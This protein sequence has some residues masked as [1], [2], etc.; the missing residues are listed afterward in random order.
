MKR[1]LLCAAVL[2]MPAFAGLARADETTMMFWDPGSPTASSSKGE[3]VVRGT[4]RLAKGW[5]VAGPVKLEAWQNGRVVTAEIISFDPASRSWGG[6]I[7]GLE[8]GRP[9]NV[10]V[11]V[12]VSDGTMEPDTYA[13]LGEC[14][15]R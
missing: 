13:L 7:Q 9:Y 1:L 10:L 2:G 12:P 3:V 6:S 5:V 4:I 15:V 8:S 11:T 14:T